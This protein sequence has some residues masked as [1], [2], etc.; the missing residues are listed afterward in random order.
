MDQAKPRKQP[1]AQYQEPS[2][3]EE[4]FAAVSQWLSL[5]GRPLAI[6]LIIGILSLGGFIW[7]Q[8]NR[9]QASLND[10]SSARILSEE[11]KLGEE[12]SLTKLQALISLHPDLEMR[13]GGILIENM[14]LSDSP[15]AQ[16]FLENFIKKNK[17]NPL[18]KPFEDYSAGTDAVVKKEAAKALEEARS[19]QAI[20]DAQGSTGSL[21][22]LKL[23]NLL[24]ISFLARE[25]GEAK[26]AEKA[27]DQLHS[28]EAKAP[29]AYKEFTALFNE[30]T[31]TLNDL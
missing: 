30:G 1:L 17:A 2:G 13:Y 15:E 22:H 19:L 23:F 29:A 31:I 25:S 16:V 11:V 28:M 14:I 3:T 10:F 26:E 18:L 6:G 7:Y 24:R 27:L 8:S 12:G 5:Y 20:L 4:N 9:I 21:D